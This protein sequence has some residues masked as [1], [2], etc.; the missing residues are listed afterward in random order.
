MHAAPPAC[1]LPSPS[2]TQVVVFTASQRVY[3]EQL[4]NVIDPRRALIRHRVYRESC[5]FWEG[6]Y[7]KDLTGGRAGGALF[8][9][10]VVLGLAHRGLGPA[11]RRTTAAA[12]RTRRQ[13]VPVEGRRVLGDYVSKA[14]CLASPLRAAPA[15]RRVALR[16]AVLGRDLRDTVIIDNSPQAFG[17]QIDNGIPI[18]S[19]WV[20]GG[21]GV[22]GWVLC[23]GGVCA[24]CWVVE[25]GVLGGGWW[26]GG[27][28]VVEWWVLGRCAKGGVGCGRGGGPAMSRPTRGPRLEAARSVPGC[29]R[30]AA[31]QLALACP[32][33]RPLCQLPARLQVR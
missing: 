25:W 4:L 17:F 14:F 23:G 5:V 32:D 15:S 7:L 2:L 21:G 24:G 13:A 29:C 22:E 33:C 16:C 30:P 20:L 10:F 18:E 3:A 31:A 1:S 9:V 19:W 12:S 28:W 27:R 6:N 26:R 8:P 11:G